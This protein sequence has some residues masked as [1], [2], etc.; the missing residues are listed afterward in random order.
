MSLY[1]AI[2]VPKPSKAPIESTR[3]IPDV[4]SFGR[5]FSNSGPKALYLL[6]SLANRES[7]FP[8]MTVPARSVVIAYVF[9]IRFRK[10]IRDRTHEFNNHRLTIFKM[11]YL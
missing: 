2:V 11:K 8:P 4:V 7:N 6:R 9:G 3:D 5:I 10:Q 1:A